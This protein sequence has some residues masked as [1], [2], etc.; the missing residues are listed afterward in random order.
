MFEKLKNLNVDRLIDTDEAVAMHAT[1][2]ALLGTYAEFGMEAPGWLTANL[3][4][5]T[6]EIRARNAE[7]VAKKLADLKARRSSLRT[8]AEQRAD[9]EAEIA[10]L[11]AASATA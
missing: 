9:I 11:E 6:R 1:G 10:R 3:A 4:A 5:L 2:K 7:N 8:A